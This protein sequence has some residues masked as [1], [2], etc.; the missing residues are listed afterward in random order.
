MKTVDLTPVAFD[1]RRQ[2]LTDQIRMHAVGARSKTLHPVRLSHAV[3]CGQ[4]LSQL[5]ELLPH[6]HWDRWVEDQCALSRATANR[7][8]RLASRTDRLA[9]Q[10]TLREAYIAAGVINQTSS[11]RGTPQA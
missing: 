7:Y 1:Q 9:P 5:K 11:R 3:A 8:M 2:L 4:A 10:M 6:G